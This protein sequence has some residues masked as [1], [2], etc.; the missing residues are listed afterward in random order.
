MK[1]DAASS[2]TDPIKDSD[3][4]EHGEQQ[5]PPEPIAPATSPT[6]SS[7]QKK[8]KAADSL[9]TA[10]AGTRLTRFEPRASGLNV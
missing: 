10:T 1:Q 2:A 9:V 4:P 7:E 8:L 3:P 6:G 5:Q